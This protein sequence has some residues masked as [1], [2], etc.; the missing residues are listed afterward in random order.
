[1]IFIEGPRGISPFPSGLGVARPRSEPRLFCCLGIF[2]ILALA[3][4]ASRTLGRHSRPVAACQS[5]ADGLA[6]V[7]AVPLPVRLPG[8]CDPGGRNVIIAD[9]GDKPATEEG[10]A[11]VAIQFGGWAMVR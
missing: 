11:A 7:P 1:M 5:L 6:A 9:R 3:G 4:L 10:D 8:R 2:L